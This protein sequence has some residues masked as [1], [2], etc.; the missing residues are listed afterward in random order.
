MRDFP[1]AP[2]VVVGVDGSSAARNAAVWA[3]DEAV[4]RDITLRLVYVI[5]PADLCGAD[6]DR[7][8]FASGRA[9]LYDTQR[10]IE[11]TGEPVKIETEIVFGKP[12]RELIRES[13]SAAM[14][15]VGSIGIK[16]ARHGVGS[17]AAGLPEWAQCPVAVIRP[18][19]RR[20]A[21]REPGSIVV[22]AYNGVVLRHAFEEARLRAAPLRIVALWRAEAPD[23]VDD[24]TRLVQAHLNRRIAAWRRQYPD[25][26]V[27]PVAVRGSVCGYLADNADSIQLFVSGS[28]SRICELGKADNAGCSVLTV[29]YNH[30]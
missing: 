23:D 28:R 26:D 8:Q 1:S 21:T 30:L 25:V 16:H 12:L 3:V 11:A 22:E 14:V 27:E 6:A 17:V 5:D 18:P 10:A 29:R 24:E 13:R 7:I 2:S 4:S 9:A 20:P 15:S 19:V